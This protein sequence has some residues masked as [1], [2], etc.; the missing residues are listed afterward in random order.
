MHRYTL[1]LHASACLAFAGLPVYSSQ[2]SHL[3]LNSFIKRASPGPGPHL[4]ERQLSGLKNLNVTRWDQ[5]GTQPGSK[6]YDG[7][8]VPVDLTYDGF[9][10]VIKIGGQKTHLM[11][12][13]DA[14]ASYLRLR[15]PDFKR[16]TK[17]REYY[18]LKD[19]PTVNSTNAYIMPWQGTPHA[20]Y[21][22]NLTVNM[23]VAPEV[24]PKFSMPF[25]I[26]KDQWPYDILAAGV[27]G[28]GLEGGQCLAIQTTFMPRCKGGDSCETPI[29]L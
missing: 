8:A 18:S 9:V 1:L 19:P 4:V 13:N 17:H 26:F 12:F 20:Q 24:G 10:A 22:G 6:L 25:G 16:T 15:D 2:Y 29:T 3:L 11:I 21:A 5:N 23:E 27:L 28:L 14:R 7:G